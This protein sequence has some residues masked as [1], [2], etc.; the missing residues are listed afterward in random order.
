MSL[1]VPLHSVEPKHLI[2]SEISGHMKADTKHSKQ[3]NVCSLMHLPPSFL[4]Y[5]LIEGTSLM[6]HHKESHKEPSL[7]LYIHLYWRCYYGIDKDALTQF[8]KC[9]SYKERGWMFQRNIFNLISVTLV[10]C[11]CYFSSW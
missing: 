7:L 6:F 1:D 5:R 3:I 8:H 10:H 11:R 4:S 2:T 9:S